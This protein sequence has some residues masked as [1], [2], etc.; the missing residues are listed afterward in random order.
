MEYLH[1]VSDI[2]QQK[3]QSRLEDV[4]WFT[5]CQKALDATEVTGLENL[6]ASWGGGTSQQA[7]FRGTW[8]L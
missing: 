5:D 2:S 6:S 3:L 8:S 7:K 4:M 1:W